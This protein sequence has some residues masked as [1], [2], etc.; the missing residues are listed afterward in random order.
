MLS[1]KGNVLFLILIAVALFA[2][3][4]YA[5]TQSS[6]GSGNAD[7][8][9]VTLQVSQLLQMS[10]SINTA[11]QRLQLI[12]G[13]ANN[14]ISVDNSISA[15][16]YPNSNAPVG[17]QCDIYGPNGG[18]LT[19]SMVDATWLDSDKA[20]LLYYGELLFGRNTEH[21]GGP[22]GGYNITFNVPHLTQGMCQAINDQ[23]GLGWSTI[24]TEPA[25]SFY[26]YAYGPGPAYGNHLNC[27]P[28]V[29]VGL[30]A[31]CLQIL[32]F[33]ASGEASY[34]YSEYLMQNIP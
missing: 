7:S 27:T 5:V 33:Q 20:A 26:T 24:P 16:F 9:K 19:Y 1:Q 25:Q 21:P 34:V 4:S 28:S 22:S 31:F 29:C 8:E 6:R 12:N 23:L 14:E 13:C 11:I 2:A 32:D 3:L 18:G 30:K 10:A 15:L 17:G